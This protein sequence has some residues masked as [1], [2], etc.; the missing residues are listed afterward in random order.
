MED[1]TFE[2]TRCYTCPFVC[3]G[4]EI[5]EPRQ[6][7]NKL[8]DFLPNILEKTDVDTIPHIE[9]PYI[10]ICIEICDKQYYF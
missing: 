3:K 2:N 4:A 1:N 7:K 10:T 9:K 8:K 6:I 5:C